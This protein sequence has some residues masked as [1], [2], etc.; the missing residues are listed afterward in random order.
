MFCKYCGATVKQ[1][2]RFCI[3]CGK[4][5]SATVRESVAAQPVS[6]PVTAAP[7]PGT[8]PKPSA[9][10]TNSRCWL[11]GAYGMAAGAVLLAVILLLAGVLSFGGPKIEGPGFNTPEDAARAYLNGLRNQ[12][13]KAMLSA[14]AVESYVENY[15]L[16][17]FVERIRAYLPSM[18]IRLPNSNAYNVQLNIASRRNQLM[19]M[20]ANQYL[21]YNSPDALNNFETVKFE[22]PGD[23]AD[24]IEGIERDTEKYVFAD[25]KI[26]DI[27]EPEDVSEL[28]SL[29][30]N[31][32]NIARQANAIGVDEDDV[33]NIAVMF[34]ADGREWLFC[35]QAIRYNGK[36]YLQKADGNLS[37]LVGMPF[38]CGGIAP[39]DTLD[40]P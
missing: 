40:L 38:F 16:E 29:D 5:L 3:K 19:S 25:L 14:F 13:I 23:I 12:D 10:R 28:Y 33:T 20:I 39:M 18:E 9:K 15:D 11:F 4:E 22:D 34:E 37:I 21:Y 27:L 31:I 35:P 2:D 6:P 32:E 8:G 17:A 24:F 1:G 7:E 26:V 30:V 36:W